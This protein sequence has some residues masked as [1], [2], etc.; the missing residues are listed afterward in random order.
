L[1]RLPEQL[2]EIGFPIAHADDQRRRTQALELTRFRAH[3]WL[4]RKGEVHD[5]EG[6]A[7]RG[8]IRQG[9]EVWARRLPGVGLVC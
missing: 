3:P 9:P 8:W 5:A 1:L 4:G 2:V 7:R 6:A